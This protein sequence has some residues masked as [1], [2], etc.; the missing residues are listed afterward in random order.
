[1]LGDGGSAHYATGEAVANVSMTLS[2]HQPHPRP[3]RSFLPF[4]VGRNPAR[5]TRKVRRPLFF[6]VVRLFSV[7]LLSWSLSMMCECLVAF[8]FDV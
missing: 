2:L 4:Q 7:R 3:F 8:P 5:L 6:F 1:M